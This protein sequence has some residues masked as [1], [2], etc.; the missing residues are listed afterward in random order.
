[1]AGGADRVLALAGADT[2]A[3]AVVRQAKRL[4]DALRAPWIVLHL[5]RPDGLDT[6]SPALEMAASLGAEIEIRAGGPLVATALDLARARNVTHL[7]IGR[8]RPN[9]F[10]RI[11]G[12]TLAGTLVSQGP[13][14]SLHVVPVSGRPAP[15]RRLAWLPKTWAPWVA[16]TAFVALVLAA[17][18]IFHGWLQHEALGMLFLAAVVAAATFGGLTVAL[19]AATLSYVTWD[20]AF[21][22]PVGRFT[23][24]D[25]RDFVALLVFAGVAIATGWLASRVRR[26]ATAAQGRI[27]S[28]RRISAFSRRLGEPVSEPDLLAEVAKLASEIVSPATVL[29]A[30]GEDINIRA[31]QPASLDTMDE[32]SWAAARWAFSRQEQTGRGTATLPSAAWRFLPLHTARHDFGVLGVRPSGGIDQALVQSLA[33]LADQAAAALE[34]VRLTAASARTEAQAETQ[35]LRTALLRSLSHDLR[36]PLTGIRG[37]AGSLRTS[38][39]TLPPEIRLDLLASIELD[40]VRMTRFLANITEMTRL[41]TG[42]IAPRVAA[43]DLADIAQAAA[44]RVP[45]LG[46]RFARTSARIAETCGG[47]RLARA[48]AGQSFRKC[49]QIWRRRRCRRLRGAARR[50]RHRDPGR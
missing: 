1:M 49:R 4:A 46:G 29:I 22:P 26:E 23:M 9:F 20:V 47:P 34:R 2:A 50:E 42:D 14:F 15:P 28:L 12:K 18:E 11:T 39:A 24:Q 25:P 13:E 16:S 6:T 30:E 21:V 8:G 38:W 44:A 43:V 5:E 48:G 31:S 27:E 7:V 33:S 41:E 36:T 17:G 37:A 32:G 35:K 10:R 40:V 45:G 3:E 19:Y